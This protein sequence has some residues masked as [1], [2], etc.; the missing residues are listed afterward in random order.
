MPL[1]VDIQDALELTKLPVPPAMR[2]VN[3]KAEDYTNWEGEP[4][5]L[6]TV[7]MHE[8]TNFKNI[9][10]SDILALSR[11]IHDNLLNCG[12]QLFPYVRYTTRSR[13]RKV[14]KKL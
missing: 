5:L 6:I 3:I 9:K 8:Y 14:P 11:V 7:L 2:I 1:T 13:R 4:A 12:I 10:G